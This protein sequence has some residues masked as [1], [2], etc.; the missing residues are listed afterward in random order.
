MTPV[1]EIQYMYMLLR[2]MGEAIYM[3]ELTDAYMN[4]FQNIFV[5]RF[6]RSYAWT[7]YRFWPY[8]YSGRHPWGITISFNNIH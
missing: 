2:S 3:P 5:L 1:L 8:E 6:I 7:S 4:I